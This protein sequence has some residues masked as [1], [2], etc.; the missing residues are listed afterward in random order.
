[1]LEGG[2]GT[3]VD[4]GKLLTGRLQVRRDAGSEHLLSHPVEET[5]LSIITYYDIRFRT[6]AVHGKMITY[7]ILYTFKYES[8]EFM[9]C[10]LHIQHII[11]KHVK[12]AFM[13]YESYSRKFK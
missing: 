12:F 4:R 2:G 1:M 6:R 7:S 9:F 11:F 10:I 8:Y 13:Y 3:V 5:F